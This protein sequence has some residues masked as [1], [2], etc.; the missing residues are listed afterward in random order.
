MIG[1]SHHRLKAFFGFLCI[2]L[3]ILAGCTGGGPA[4]EADCSNGD[5]FFEH[6]KLSGDP[7]CIP[8]QPTRIVALDPFTFEAMIALDA[9]LVAS[10]DA[11]MR[12][13]LTHAPQLAPQLEEVVNSGIPVNYETLI[14]LEPDIIL[15]RRTACNRQ[16]RR[17]RQIAPTVVFDNQSAADWR[18]SARFFAEAIGMQAE[19]AALEAGYDQR[20]EMMRSIVGSEPPKISVMRIQ[21]DRLRLYFNQSF[22]GIVLTDAGFTFPVGQAIAADAN[23]DDLGRPQLA[24]ISEEELNLIEADYTFVYVTENAGEDAAQAYLD[25]LL[26]RPLW[27]SL[28]VV[29]RG[30]LHIVGIYWFAS[31]YIAAHQMLDDLSAVVLGVDPEGDNPFE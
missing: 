18:E 14:D 10:S 23:R 7:I 24:N 1:S 4:S 30:D 6:E 13:L 3:F 19:M 26:R 27:Q 5:R 16:L 31:G 12:E 20:T 21:P 28:E 25:D 22:A 11:Y 2:S 29:E 15:C 9:P 8:Q 17:L